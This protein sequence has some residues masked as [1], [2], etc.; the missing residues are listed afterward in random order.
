MK[1]GKLELKLLKLSLSF[2]GDIDVCHYDLDNKGNV[3][4]IYIMIWEGRRVSFFPEEICSLKHLQELHLWGDKIEAIPESI[5]NLK[6]LR[7]LYVTNFNGRKIKIPKSTFSF[8]KS[9]E[10]CKIE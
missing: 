3:I 2:M 7:K 6:S 5:V 9:L 4:A 1:V 10:I 8:L